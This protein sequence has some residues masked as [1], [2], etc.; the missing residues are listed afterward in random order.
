MIHFRSIEKYMEGSGMGKAGMLH[1]YCGDGKG[2]TT[3]AT[4]LAVRAA[5]SGMKVLFVRFMKSRHSAELEILEKI[6]KIRILYPEESFG[7]YSRQ[8]RETKC[9]MKQVYEKLWSQA[10]E[11]AKSGSYDMLVADEFMSAYG[12]GLIPNKDAVDFLKS[13]PPELEVVLT[14]RNPAKEVAELADYISEVRKIRHP[15]DEG[16]KARRGIEY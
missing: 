5:G 6:E 3:A 11:L 10:K 16:V 14:G 8:D 2:K 1:I 15:F 4:G 9:R 12:Y 7:F 13:R